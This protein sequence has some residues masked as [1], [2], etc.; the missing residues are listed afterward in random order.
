MCIL[1]SYSLFFLLFILSILPRDCCNIPWELVFF[2]WTTYELAADMEFC[3]PQGFNLQVISCSLLLQD[4][5]LLFRLLAFKPFLFMPARRLQPVFLKCYTVVNGEPFADY[6]CCFRF[7]LIKDHPLITRELALRLHPACWENY[8]CARGLLIVR[9]LEETT[10]SIQPLAHDEW[11]SFQSSN[12][13]RSSISSLSGSG[14]SL[15]FCKTITNQ[16]SSW[17][18]GLIAAVCLICVLAIQ[19]SRA[20]RY[21]LRL[22]LMCQTESRMNLQ[23]ACDS[24][25][26]LSLQADPCA[27][28]MLWIARRL[29]LMH[30]SFSAWRLHP[31]TKKARKGNVGTVCTPMKSKSR[32]E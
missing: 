31:G 11:F 12:D 4:F 8:C 9:N 22:V 32:G 17:I 24:G 2:W 20:I 25:R 3:K 5:F 14:S 6:F 29:L 28:L 30:D 13:W 23:P 15:S 7:N 26:L 16:C 10:S 21:L 19:P 18:H 27:R 1:L